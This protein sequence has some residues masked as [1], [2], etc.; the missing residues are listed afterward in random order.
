[1]IGDVESKNPASHPC[2]DAPPTAWRSGRRLGEPIGY[3][4][5]LMSWMLPF[6][7]RHGLLA[8]GFFIAFL[9]GQS[10][11]L[12]H[13]LFEPG[14]NRTDCAFASVGERTQGLPADA[15]T[16]IPLALV[17]TDATGADRLALPSRTVVPPDARAPPL[18]AP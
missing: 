16:L 2:G 17:G 11:H 3:N 6:R 12:V 13:H 8:T 9:V 5:G 4:G 1:M 7:S 10:P 18:L 14:Q 15:V